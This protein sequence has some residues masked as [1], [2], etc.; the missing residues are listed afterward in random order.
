MGWRGSTR[1]TPTLCAPHGACNA[2]V[3]A[4][5]S[6]PPCS[7]LAAQLS[8]QPETVARC[9]TIWQVNYQL[10][11]QMLPRLQMLVEE[12]WWEVSAGL[13]KICS[14]LLSIPPAA[15]SEEAPAVRDILLAVL[16]SRNPMV[17]RTVLPDAA[18]V[19]DSQPAVGSAFSVALLGLPPKDRTAL[20]QSASCWPALPV[21]QALLE[22]AKEQSLEHLVSAHAEVLVAVLGGPLATAEREGW[23]AWLK[24]NKDYLYVSL[25]DEDLCRYIVSV[26]A[27]ES[28]S[29]MELDPPPPPAPQL[30]PRAP[31]AVPPPRAKRGRPRSGRLF[32]A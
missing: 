5:L 20:L 8:L 13:G 30:E 3:A 11:L 22:L 28:A 12:P 26:A 25:C 4:P 6:H 9:T 23:Q 24:V 32:L 31:E 7:L 29:P 1:A 21:A 2:A 17:L 19:L 14:M 27:S 18:M 15:A 16:A 10:V